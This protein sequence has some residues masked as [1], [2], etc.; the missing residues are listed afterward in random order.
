MNATRG[1]SAGIAALHPIVMG[2]RRVLL[3][4]PV[5][6]DGDSIGGIL[7]LARIL[8]RVNPELEVVAACAEPVP[9]RY[10]FLEDVE[11]FVLAQDL[12]GPFDVALLLDG[13]RHRIGDVGPHF[14]AAGTRV[15]VDHHRSSDPAGYELALL[16][17]RRASTCDIVYEIARHPAFDVTVD[18]ATAQQLYT[19]VVFDTGTFRYSCTT[20]DTLRLAAA[21]LE[22]GIDAQQIVE[23]VFLDSPFEDTLF[24]GRVLSEIRLAAGGR[25]A[26]ACVSHALRVETRASAAATEGVINSLIFIEGV[27]VAVLLSERPEGLVRISFRSRGGVNVAEVA[28]SLSPEG[29]G[30]DRASGATLEGPL[31]SALERVLAGIEPRL[32]GD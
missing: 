20:S 28:A 24:R 9:R 26:Y 4:G 22:T 21:L 13:V 14:D 11:R 2:A 23:R 3:T 30:H 8:E 1:L 25:L 31:A 5:E 15:L 29:G 6:A 18:R 10:R 7:A 32:M 27:E 19:G 12:A 16:D 17:S